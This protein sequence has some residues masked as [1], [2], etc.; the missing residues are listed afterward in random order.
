ML[1]RSTPL[2]HV[3]R[4]V[5]NGLDDGDGWQRVEGVHHGAVFGTYLHG[6]VLARNPELADEVLRAAV[7]PLEPFIDEL[8]D[9]LAQERRATL[10]GGAAS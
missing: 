2:G 5:G 7:G 10:W 1:F 6:P 4:G 3:L 9:Q 8:A